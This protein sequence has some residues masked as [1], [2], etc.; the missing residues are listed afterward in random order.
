M[1]IKTIMRYHMPVTR[2][3]AKSKQNKKH[4]N[5]C[6][7]WFGEEFLSSIGVNVS[8]CSSNEKPP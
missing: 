1:Q 2:W 3:L 4:I 5:S 7:Q 8:W 6:W